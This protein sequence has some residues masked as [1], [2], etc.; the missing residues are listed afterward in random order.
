MAHF[1]SDTRECK[2]TI[3]DHKLGPY[4]RKVSRNCPMSTQS[5]GHQDITRMK[6][7]SA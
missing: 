2:D 5:R 4:Q 3:H 1:N 7:G 6:F